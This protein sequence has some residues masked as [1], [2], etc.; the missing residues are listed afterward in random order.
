MTDGIVRLLP[1][2]RALRT[3]VAALHAAELPDGEMTALGQAFLREFYYGALLSD[4]RYLCY[5]Y[6]WEGRVAGSTAFSTDSAA[7][8]RASVLRHA[9]H[10]AW[11]VVRALLERPARLRLV[12]RL[13]AA[14]LTMRDEP[15]ADVR[16]EAM[17][18]AVGRAYRT[19]EFHRATGKNVARELYLNMGRVLFGLGVRRVRGFTRPDNVLVSA[20]LRQLGWQRVAEARAIRG[21]AGSAV[22]WVWDLTAA[23]QRWSFAVPR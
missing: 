13:A 4:P 2:M 15:A 21:S 10:L 16:A 1:S 23:A 19:V 14:S 12:V 9:A 7:V 22:V 5:V 20:S 17:T 3:E 18:T 8:V 6:L 11:I